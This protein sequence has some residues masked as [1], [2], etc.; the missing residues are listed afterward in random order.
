L[1]QFHCSHNQLFHKLL[2]MTRIP[3]L[4]LFGRT[5][6]S[7]YL[8]LLKNLILAQT[9]LRV[10]ETLW[11]WSLPGGTLAFREDQAWRVVALFLFGKIFFWSSIY[12]FYTKQNYCITDLYE[13]LYSILFLVKHEL[14][15]WNLIF[16]QIFLRLNN[17]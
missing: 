2:P 11:F 9:L 5:S 6:S 4:I 14:Q 8:L 16:H 13:P 17:V 1:Q 10:F 3:M 7:F 12:C 15:A